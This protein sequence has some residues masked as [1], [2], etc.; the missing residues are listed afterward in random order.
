MLSYVLS[1]HHDILKALFA[2]QISLR[3]V[4]KI[5]DVN[6]KVSRMSRLSEAPQMLV[7]QYYD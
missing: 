1:V 6:A 2:G 3:F 4:G 7:M 5:T